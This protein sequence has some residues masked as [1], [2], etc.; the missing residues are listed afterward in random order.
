M[1]EKKMEDLTREELI[2]LCEKQENELKLA[3]AVKDMY[4]N[5]SER[6]KAKIKT[7]ETILSL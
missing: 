6:L 5:D 1:A 2:K 4:Y 3:R 7:I